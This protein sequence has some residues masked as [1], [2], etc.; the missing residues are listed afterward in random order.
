[1]MANPSRSCSSVMHSGG[2]QVKLDQRTKVKRPS[3]R[4]NLPSLSM[5]G[6][7]PL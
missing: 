1:M 7:L 4:K 6:W 5:A 3:S 2:T